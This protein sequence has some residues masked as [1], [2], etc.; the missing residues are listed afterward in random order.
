MRPIGLRMEFEPRVDAA[1]GIDL[2]MA[3]EITEFEGF[4]NYGGPD[5][6]VTQPVFRSMKLKTSASMQ[7]GSFIII[8]GLGQSGDHKLTPQPGA[9][10]GK[11]V[12]PSKL[13]DW[14]RATKAMFF[15]IQAR[16]A[17]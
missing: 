3:P 4:V 8:G 15:L 1:G 12:D 5:N 2:D 7:D 10:D 16:V 11:E 9:I 14:K 13:P 17:N 6:R